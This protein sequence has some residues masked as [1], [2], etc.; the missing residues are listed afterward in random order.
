MTFL[1]G[2]FWPSKS[3]SS[4]ETLFFYMDTTCLL[5]FRT[6]LILD[7]I[8]F[9][10]SVYKYNL[11]F[12]FVPWRCQLG[13]SLEKKSFNC[14][15]EPVTPYYRTSSAKVETHSFGSTLD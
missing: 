15:F 1:G 14:K 2:K 12:S 8:A 9:D 4:V 6:W 10:F 7:A 5:V 3:S 11:A 13:V